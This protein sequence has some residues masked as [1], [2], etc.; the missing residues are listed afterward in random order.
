MLIYLPTF[1]NV[2]IF[3]AATGRDI[4]QRTPAERQTLLDCL[5]TTRNIVGAWLCWLA[6]LFGGVPSELAVNPVH[7]LHTNNIQ[8]P[9]HRSPEAVPGQV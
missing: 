4:S 6:A 1:V 9:S 8:L 2:G 7:L 3:L 5:K